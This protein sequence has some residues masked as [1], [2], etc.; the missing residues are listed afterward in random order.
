MIIYKSTN[1]INGMSYIGKDARDS[2]TYLG[3]GLLVKAA[4]KKYG[5]ENF[6][7]ETLEVCTSLEQMTKR[8]KYWIKHFNAVSDPMF[9]NITEG[10]D[11]GDVYS[12][13]PNKEDIRLKNVATTLGRKWIMNVE[14]GK[15]RYVKKPELQSFL[16]NGWVKTTAPA[17]KTYDP[18]NTVWIHEGSSSKMIRANDLDNYLAK[19]WTKGRAPRNPEWNENNRRAQIARRIG[20]DT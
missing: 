4:I 11:G 1:L 15:H 2:K 6:V 8:E 12:N 10:G 17:W 16:D 3:S 18:K 7:K 14:T 13:N 20:P 19:G 5:R 9:Y